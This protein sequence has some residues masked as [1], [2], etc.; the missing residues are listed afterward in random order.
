MMDLQGVTIPAGL[1]PQI[2]AG[3][4]PPVPALAFAGAVGIWIC[5]NEFI[6]GDLIGHMR[7]HLA[8]LVPAP[9]RGPRSIYIDSVLV[10]R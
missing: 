2:P 10:L 9:G 1:V 7:A 4:P 6:A 5:A 8:P 3:F